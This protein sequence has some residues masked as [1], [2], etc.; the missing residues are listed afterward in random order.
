MNNIEE[1]ESPR[2]TFKHKPRKC[3]HCD[4]KPLGNILYG[5]PAGDDEMI[6]EVKEGR[7]VLGGCTIIEGVQQPRWE[8]SQ[9]G[10]Q[11]WKE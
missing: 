7:I 9:C 11:G 6:Q 1:T 10:W 2:P 8:C 3:P 4:F 5:F